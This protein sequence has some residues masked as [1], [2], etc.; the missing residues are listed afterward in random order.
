MDL[1]LVRVFVVIYETQ[2]LTAAA[3]RLFVTQSAVSQ[4]LARLRREVGDPLFERTA[5]VM[6]PTPLAD[7]LFPGFRDAIVGVDRALGDVRGFDPS[8]TTRRLR[9][10]MS[11]LGEVGWLPRIAEELGRLAPGAGIEVVPLA[12]ASIPEQL[13]RGAIDIAISPVDLPGGFERAVVKWQEYGVAMS[14]ANPLAA[15]S[16]TPETYLAAPRVAVLGDSGASL[17]A[18][19]ERRHGDAAEPAVLLQHFATLPALLTA[20]HDLVAAVPTSIAEQW[21]P[22]WRLAVL[23]L[24]LQ[25]E[26][27]RIRVYRRISTPNRGALEWFYDLVTRVV[28]ST[29]SRF[30]LLVRAGRADA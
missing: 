14:S 21:I 19:A 8:T 2:S 15:S 23:P 25:M 30:D 24:P 17:L 28:S 4:S 5:R 16:L 22:G 29:P 3:D 13:S 12:P 26:P 7:R 6:S 10:A 20:R 1:N 11:E 27:I 18:A 9:I